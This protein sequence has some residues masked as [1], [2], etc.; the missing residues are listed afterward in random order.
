MGHLTAE[1]G[2]FNVVAV[3]FC[4][5]LSKPLSFLE[6]LACQICGFSLQAV[7]LCTQG[8]GLRLPSCPALRSF[9][10]HGPQMTRVIAVPA[11][12]S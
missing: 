6:Q 1:A 2:G 8:P 7:N 5:Q 4:C 3:T 10:H 9:L 11:D 12:R